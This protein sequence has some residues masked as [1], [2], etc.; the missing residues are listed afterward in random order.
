MV[1]KN[2]WRLTNQMNYLK[3]AKLIHK[4]YHSKSSSSDHDHC[5]FC[6]EKFEN[7]KV[8][9]Y[10]TLD[11]YHW[12]CDKCFDDFKDMFEWKIVKE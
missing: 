7:G 5:E 9:G 12:I 1:D 10:C 4:K 6:W 2:D 3:Q 11:N 8:E